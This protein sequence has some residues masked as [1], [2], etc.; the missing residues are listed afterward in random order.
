MKYLEE[1]DLAVVKVVFGSW[2]GLEVILSHDTLIFLLL[3]TR[4]I[5]ELQT[6]YKHLQIFFFKT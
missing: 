5:Q 2:K 6:P 4:E 1:S 3:E